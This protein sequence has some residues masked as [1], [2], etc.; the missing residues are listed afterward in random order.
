[1]PR[2]LSS[3]GRCSSGPARKSKNPNPKSEP[4]LP[5]FLSD[6]GFGISGVAFNTESCE[7][8]VL[9]VDGTRVW[10]KWLGDP[11]MS[12][13]AV[14]GGRIYMAHPDGKATGHHALVCFDLKT[15]QEHWKKPIAG[16]IITAPVLHGGQVHLDSEIQNRKSQIQN[17][18]G[19]EGP[20]VDATLTPPALV[21]GK[22]FVGTSAGEVL[23]L[24]ADSGK[25]LW[26]ATLGEPVSFQPA[27]AAGSTSHRARECSSVWRRATPRTTAG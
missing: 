19:G 17:G 27:V 10:K 22:V 21:N 8:E 20:V 7:L 3:A 2:R 25:E 14:A 6:F 13:P 1:L 26:R 11:L 23:C 24:S 5:V 16:E 18:A 9:T 15:G 12:M 4:D